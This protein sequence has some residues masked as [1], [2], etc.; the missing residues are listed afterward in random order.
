M[1]QTGLTAT[2]LRFAT[3]D[4]SIEVSHEYHYVVIFCICEV[5]GEPQMKDPAKVLQ[6]QW[7]GTARA[8][9][10]PCSQSSPPIPH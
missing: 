10:R 8:P 4:N 2:N 6:W 3:L 5:E 9:G 1:E 7:S